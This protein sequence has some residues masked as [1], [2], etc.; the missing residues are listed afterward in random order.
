M[1]KNRKLFHIVLLIDEK[2][3]YKKRKITKKINFLNNLTLTD[4]KV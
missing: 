4:K 3:I 2:S 1:L